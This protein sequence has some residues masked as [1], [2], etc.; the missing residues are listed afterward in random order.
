MHSGV[1]NWADNWT[2]EKG[3]TNERK[4]KQRLEEEANNEANNEANTSGT[5]GKLT[6][7][8]KVKGA[9]AKLIAAVKHTNLENQRSLADMFDSI[10]KRKADEAFASDHGV[11]DKRTRLGKAQSKLGKNQPKIFDSIKKV[12]GQVTR[13][14]CDVVSEGSTQPDQ[15]VQETLPSTGLSEQPEVES[16]KLRRSERCQGSRRGT[17]TQS[18]SD[19]EL[20]V[21]DVGSQLTSDPDTS[22]LGD[23]ESEANVDGAQDLPSSG[24]QPDDVSNE[25]EFTFDQGFTSPLEIV[26]DITPKTAQT[27]YVLAPRFEEAKGTLYRIANLFVLAVYDHVDQGTAMQSRQVLAILFHELD[28]KLTTPEQKEHYHRFCGNWCKYQQHVKNGGSPEGYVRTRNGVFAGIDTDYQNAFRELV[29][30]FK[31]LGSHDLMQR[32]SM[33]ITTNMAESI[34][35]RLH[36]LGSKAKMHALARL[37]FCAEQVMLTSNFGQIKSN[38]ACVFG[39]QSNVAVKDLKILQAYS[40]RSAERTHDSYPGGVHDGTRTK[41]R[42]EK[43]QGKPMPAPPPR[44][45]DVAKANKATARAN[46]ETAK[47]KKEAAR[48]QTSAK[49]KPTTPSSYVGNGQA[50]LPTSLPPEYS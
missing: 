38:L 4:R 44:A 36:L 10:K 1:K 29:A 49:K 9:S 22:R 37:M 24:S 16:S 43:K 7:N 2:V 42:P 18:F 15:I 46:K 41:T 47:A 8:L 3:E 40:H 45:K 48:R 28:H 35:A 5:K 21:D 17:F 25:P 19:E 23:V 34:H 50:D 13:R 33:P 30:R 6:K 14:S 27:K 39:T 26:E 32:C 20:S 31:H 11:V 12:G